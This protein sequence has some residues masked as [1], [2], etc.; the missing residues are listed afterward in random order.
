MAALVTRTLTGILSHITGATS[1]ATGVNIVFTLVDSQGRPASVFD[2]TTGEKISGTTSV[3]TD[4]SGAF[5]INLWPTD[6][7]TKSLRYKCTILGFG[8]EAIENTLAS[9]ASPITF[10]DWANG[11]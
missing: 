7:S 4:S 6:R 5:T 9:G 1:A 2:D 3:V 10:M 8:D 11:A